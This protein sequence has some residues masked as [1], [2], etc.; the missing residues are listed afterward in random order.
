[1]KNKTQLILGPGAGWK[2]QTYYIVNVS[3]SENNVIHKA[4]FFTGFLNNGK[5]GSY[6]SIHCP[7]YERPH[8]IEE[9]YS[10]EVK[11]EL[12]TLDNPYDIYSP[13]I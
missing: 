8:R 1:M 2:A 12:Y 6:N 7:G 4:L 10:L 5:P 11:H 9:V 3:Y 13:K